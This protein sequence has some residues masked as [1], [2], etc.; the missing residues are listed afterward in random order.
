M[1]KLTKDWWKSRTLLKAL[2]VAVGGV[3]AALQV[4]SPEL[5]LTGAVALCSALADVLL[6]L[7]TTTRLK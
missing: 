7:D 4:D 1:S 5:Q 3:L 2:L 6:R